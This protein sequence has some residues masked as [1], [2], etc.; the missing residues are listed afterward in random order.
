MVRRRAITTIT[1][2]DGFPE[3]VYRCDD[4]ALAAKVLASVK[5]ICSSRLDIMMR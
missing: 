3:A 1:S 4:Q 2:F 5:R